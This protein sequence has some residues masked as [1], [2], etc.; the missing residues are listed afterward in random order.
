MIK[1]KKCFVCAEKHDRKSK[2]CSRR[3]VEWDKKYFKKAKKQ[4]KVTMFGGRR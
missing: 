4:R 2:Y 3:C 1:M